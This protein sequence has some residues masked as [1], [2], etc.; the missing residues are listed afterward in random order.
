M[1]KSSIRVVLLCHF[2]DPLLREK[3]DLQKGYHMNHKDYGLWNVNIINGLK[4]RDDIE[5]HVVMPHKGLRTSIQE[6][7]WDTV[8][9]H[10][11]RD[12]LPFPFGQIEAYLCPQKKRG[13]PRNRKCVR[14]LIYKIKPDIINLIGAENTYYSLAT[15]DINDIP[16]IIHCQTVYA[17]PDR[18][19][20][21][22]AID[23]QRWDDEVRLFRKVPYIACTGRMYY[24]LIKEYAP[25]AIIFPEKW[26]AALFPTIKDV[27]KRYDFAYYARMLNKNKGFDNLI[28][29][30]GI[31]V[32]KYPELKVVAVGTWGNDKAQF[33]QRIHEL[34]I[35]DNI[36]IHPSFP[37][38]NDM[39]Q[40]VKQAKYALLPIKMDVLSGTIIEAMR[41][42]M[43]VVTSRTSGTPALNKK[44]KTVLISDIGDNEGL[45]KNML[46]LYESPKLA[47][48]LKEN[49]NQY[50]AELDESNS[51]N[52][53]TMVAQY[54]AVIAHY[55]EGVSIPKELLYDLEE[56]IDYR[57]K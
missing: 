24:D 46:D 3:M 50:L 15:L 53:N 22:G 47:E 31:V 28:E 33:E 44:R 17:N 23:Q 13:F 49:A 7:V 14:S 39:L 18:I 30:V 34:G 51:H 26:P 36:E 19:K 48:E 32:K 55:R 29:A 20:R 37:E 35:S 4:N 9:Y 40:Y 10:V 16:V 1:I 21:A 54:K 57:K 25:D 5:L 41:M 43:P 11:F 6:F 8:Y 45:A 56:N 52:I 27:P 42:G 12:E 38:Y 2:T